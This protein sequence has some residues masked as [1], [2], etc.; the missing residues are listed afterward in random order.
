MLLAIVAERSV[1]L[2]ELV[3]R[4]KDLAVIERPA[5]YLV[6]LNEA[7]RA[8]GGADWGQ[9]TRDYQVVVPR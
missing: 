8:S 9:A 1:Q 3:S 7:L 4:H 5:A 2:A 6:E